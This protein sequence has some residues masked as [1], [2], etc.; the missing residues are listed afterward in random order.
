MKSILLRPSDKETTKQLNQ[1]V[2][3]Q[4]RQLYEWHSNQ[5]LYWQ[6]LNGEQHMSAL[7][8]FV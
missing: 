7:V 4:L 5:L 1:A 2:L 6:Q 3:K 8:F